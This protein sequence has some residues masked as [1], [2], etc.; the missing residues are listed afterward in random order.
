MKTGKVPA[1][2]G[3]VLAAALTTGG[4]ATKKHVRQAIAPVQ[5]QVNDIDKRTNENKTA[6]GDL[7]R[8][9]ATVDEKATDAGKRASQAAD[10][11]A[12]ANRAATE[13]GQRADAANNAAT[14]AQQAAGRVDSRLDRSL[15]NLNNYRLVD[16]KQVFFRVGQSTLDQQA[17][18]ELDNALMALGNTHN[19]VI[20]VEGFADRTG[21]KA[22]NL[23]LSRRRADSVVHYLTVEHNVPLRDIRTIGVGA[24]FPNAENKT[25]ADRKNNRRVDVKIYGLDINGTGQSA[26]TSQSSNQSPNTADRETP[27]AQQ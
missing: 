5:Q 13:A 2:L 26:A 14:Q 24:E 1:V 20:E 11:A 6:I 4:C 3:A 25:R 21:S 22:L 16:T 8:T 9:V 18:A 17:R 7:D 19:F 10:A 23:E 27:R 15:Q 12:A